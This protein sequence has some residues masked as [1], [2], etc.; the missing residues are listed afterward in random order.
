MNV[1]SL[2]PK[3]NFIRHVLERTNLHVIVVSKSWL[4]KHSTHSNRLVEIPNFNLLRCDRVICQGNGVAIYIRNG[5][6]TNVLKSTCASE[7]EYLFLIV[8]RKSY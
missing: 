4:K 1:G 7:T 2:F 5:I 3:I 8:L 6:V